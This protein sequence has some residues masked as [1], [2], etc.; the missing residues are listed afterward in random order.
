MTRFLHQRLAR[1]ENRAK[2]L[3]IGAALILC[4]TRADVEEQERQAARDGR[5]VGA[6][7]ILRVI[8]G[9]PMERIAA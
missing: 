2:P 8:L 4:G 9:A 5:M 3:S 7:P 1:L 6:G